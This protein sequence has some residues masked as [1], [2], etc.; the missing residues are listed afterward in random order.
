MIQSRDENRVTETDFEMSFKDRTSIE[1]PNALD[2][3]DGCSV[4]PSPSPNRRMNSVST[5]NSTVTVEAA[6]TN[7]GHYVRTEIEPSPTVSSSS[8]KV[9]LLFLSLIFFAAAVGF[10]SGLAD[11]LLFYP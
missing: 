11:K 5:T 9:P 2:V 10:W 1:N 4:D 6:P 8:S 7:A 3:S